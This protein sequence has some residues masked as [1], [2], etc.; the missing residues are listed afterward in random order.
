MPKKQKGSYR[1]VVDYRKLNAA[2]VVDSNPL[3]RIGDILQRQGRFKIW[4]V[5]DMKDGYHQVPLKKE[6]RNLTCMSTPRGIM[7]WRVLVMGLK[8]GN[9]IFQRVM[10]DVLKDLDFV[11]A[12]V[13]DVIIGSTGSTREELLANHDRD[14]RQALDTLHAAGLFAEPSKAQLFVEEV[15][16]CG[17]ILRNG[18][19][20]PAPG[21]LLPIKNWELPP[22]L[23][24]LRGFLGLCNYYEEY[25]PGYAHQAWRLMDKLKV[26][27]PKAKAG[28]NL[29]LV[30][31]DQEKADFEALKGLLSTSLSL[32]Y[33]NPD[34][35]F[36]LRTD[37]SHT[38]IGA[39]LQQLQEGH[40]VPV[41]FF[42]RKLTQSQTNWSARDK[43]AYAIVASLVKWASW[44]GTQPLSVVTDHKSLESWVV[45]YVETPSGPTGRRARWHE[46]LSQFNLTI[47]YQPG[48]TN[49]PADCMSRY[50]YP[51]S[52]E[53]QD[54]CL[55]GSSKDS[56]TIKSYLS[57]EKEAASQDTN[58]VVQT[59][60]TYRL[61][62][63]A[64]THALNKIGVPLDWIQ[65]DLFASSSNNMHPLYITVDMN[66][67]T[68]NWSLLCTKPHQVLWANP[69]FS[70][71]NEVLTKIVLEPCRVV[72]VTPVWQDHPWWQPLDKLTVARHY[73]PPQTGIYQRSHTQPILPGPHWATAISLVDSVHWQAS[74]HMPDLVPWVR[75]TSCN[76]DRAD[77]L[78]M[79]PYIMVSTR[80]GIV[81]DADDT[82]EVTQSQDNATP[83][84]TSSSSTPPPAHTPTHIPP[85]PLQ[86][87]FKST[88]N[89]TERTLRAPSSR[90]GVPQAAPP[91]GIS[92]PENAE[93]ILDLSWDDHYAISNTFAKW[94]KDINS[95][96]GTWPAG[97]QLSNGKL[98]LDNR[99]CVPETL[100]SHVLREYHIF[101]GHMGHKRMLKDLPLHFQ[102]PTTTSLTNLLQHIT[103]HCITCQACTPPHWP[104]DGQWIPFPIPERVMHSVSLDIFSMPS[105]SWM[106]SMYDS[107]LLCVD[108]L[109]GWITACPTQKLGLS[110]EKAANLLLDRAWDFFGIPAAVH[111]DMGPQFIGQWWKTMCARLGIHHTHSPP[112]RP[113]ANGRAERAGQQLLSVLKKLHQEEK[114]NWVQALPR[115][116]HLHHNMVGTAGLSPYQIVFGRQH[117]STVLPF[118]PVRL[119]EDASHFFDR[120]TEI[121][122]LVSQ[123]LKAKHQAEST[124]NNASLPTRESYAVGDLV[125]VLK[126]RSLSSQS[127][128]EARWHG[129][130]QVLARLAQ[131]T[132]TVTDRHHSQL[133][134][135][136]DQLKPYFPLGE[137][138]ELSGLEGW[139]CALDKIIGSRDTEEGETEYLVCWL[140]KPTPSWSPHSVLLSLGWQ[141]KIEDFLDSNCPSQ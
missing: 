26:N 66:A 80:S 99:L 79:H 13:D 116:L 113:R 103:K 83:T 14:L 74:P 42:S 124:R 46:V 57:L 5:L 84:T 76:K 107:I 82:P 19:R 88:I 23:T 15:S 118:T 22:T 102:F 56:T 31:S 130:L 138:G 29:P 140:G 11:D 105:T 24:K 114:L 101:Q 4:S 100:V 47:E 12:Y 25:V 43:E 72:L 32:F 62:T 36:Q 122:S 127:K 70:L 34:Q 119:C 92:P 59:P 98:Y 97:V 90:T 121:D 128:L 85:Q 6:H 87:R 63:V 123:A 41:C 141:H 44:I 96:H 17:H 7:R 65:V 93:H 55:H 18:Q 132:Y 64:R 61:S 129:P 117:P 54:V 115:A 69:P 21:K 86:F 112:Y 35:P 53:R 1:L 75:K 89:P 110:A 49:V 95:P 67:F 30:W 20:T 91:P 60:E 52:C 68:F 48:H 16:F 73:I 39:V 111:S 136:C 10:E 27:G 51:A 109:S 8:N 40:M 28:S 126:P 2:T 81:T 38:A 125:W 50:A 131:H 135:H 9:A 94:W 71:L 134:V 77:L 78:H 37:A 45:E 139:D 106:D 108:R 137:V 120:M 3:P 58:Q 133:K 104:K 33:V